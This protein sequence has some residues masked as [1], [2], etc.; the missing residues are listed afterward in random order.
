[1]LSFFISKEEMKV[2][3][4]EL[5]EQLQILETSLIELEKKADPGRIKE[6]FRIAHT[7]KGSS[8]SI[9]YD[10]MTHLTHAM[11]SL[12]D[13]VRDGKIA[14]NSEILNLLF[15]ALD[16]L[17]KLKQNLETGKKESINVDK[18]RQALEKMA[19][20]QAGQ[21]QKTSFP[22]SV[23]LSTEEFLYEVVVRLVS[24]CD[25]PAVRAYQALL[26]LEKQGEVVQTSPTVEEL[27]E[28]SSD[29]SEFRVLL[30][31]KNSPDAILKP[32]QALSEISDVKINKI[33]EG[34]E[35]V[36][37]E[38]AEAAFM[39]ELKAS[40]TI[41][42]NVEVFD[43]L[44]NLVGELVID[45]TRLM[46]LGSELLAKGEI[47]LQATEIL[48][49]TQHLDKITTE[50]QEHIMKA[51]LVPLDLIFRKFPR[52]MRD[53]ASRSGKL[54]DFKV[55]GADTQLDRSVIEEISDPLIHLLR[56]A[57]DHGIELPEERQKA[58]KR[59]KGL[60][61]LRAFHSENQVVIQIEDDGRG[62]DP[63]KI[64]AR[65]LEKRIVSEEALASMTRS[66]LIDLIFLPG[67]STAEK[68]TDISGRGVGMDIV[69]ANLQKIGGNLEIQTTVGKGTLFT[70]KIPLTLAILQGLLVRT[71]GIVFAI[72]LSSVREIVR[73]EPEKIRRMGVREVF[74]LRGN[75]VPI[76]PLRE[77][78]GHTVLSHERIS[79]KK[80]ESQLHEDVSVLS[81]QKSRALSS[82]V[83]VSHGEKLVGI[84]VEELL[85]KQEVVIKTMGPY[86]G[87]VP[88][89][90][91]A[92]VLG[93]GT[94]ALILDVSS[95][96]TLVSQER[97]S[98]R[99]AS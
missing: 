19:G 26:E 17:K 58:G 53:F 13:G 55:N 8:A 32:L 60:I 9:G 61:E 31:S 10:E 23:S 40:R 91:G 11:E 87:D 6:I 50:L 75:V 98:F 76:V 29:F 72:P 1:M 35:N 71:L 84:L 95:F 78:Y 90:S 16:L 37:E 4:E 86:V 94:V 24:D 44:L 70:I 99:Q 80:G 27:K 45:K 74:V 57:L 68:I 36:A 92:T 39:Q 7:I 69:K 51:R 33:S 14:L 42:V 88:G 3:F 15:Q 81:S 59:P 52:M 93:N 64:K 20:K 18:V 21:K 34:K 56:N 49:T 97:Q 22:F 67:F 41:R 5:E 47:G 25:M 79:N 66:E 48:E 77:I 73:L 85:Q 83:V 46:S 2:F 30:K 89:I 12:L 38:K 65:A 62:I 43:T 82:I 96:V 28:G 54:V 63:E